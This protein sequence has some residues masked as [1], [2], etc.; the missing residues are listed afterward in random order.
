[1]HFPKVIESLLSEVTFKKSYQNTFKINPFVIRLLF[2]NA[3]F[4]IMKY[5]IELTPTSAK[6]I[7]GNMRSVACSY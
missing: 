7:Y 1:M 4:V 6:K 5:G 2:E 3:T